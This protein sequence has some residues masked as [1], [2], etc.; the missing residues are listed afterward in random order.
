MEHKTTLITRGWK[1]RMGMMDQE[2]N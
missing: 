2:K 1:F